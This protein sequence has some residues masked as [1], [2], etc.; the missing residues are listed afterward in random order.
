MAF[1]TVQKKMASKENMPMKNTGNLGNI[2]AKI[3]R[4]EPITAK[5]NNPK[6][7]KVK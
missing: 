1:K 5:K 6:L 4:N 3:T 2:R 7:K